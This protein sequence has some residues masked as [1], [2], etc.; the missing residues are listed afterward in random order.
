VADSSANSMTFNGKAGHLVTIT[1]ATEDQFVLDLVYQWQTDNGLD[2]DFE[3][4]EVWAGGFQDP[5]DEAVA[6]E[7]WTWVNGEGPFPGVNN[8]P[9]YANWAAR[10]PDDAHG[11]RSEQHLGLGFVGP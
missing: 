2:G 11:L 5:A 9:V 6:T 7:G 3:S 10:Q 4:G 8:Q 1:S